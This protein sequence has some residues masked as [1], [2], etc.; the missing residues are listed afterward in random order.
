MSE[1]KTMGLWRMNGI[2][3]GKYLVM[4]RDGTV[5]D[6]PHFVIGARDPASF[7]ALMA[8][9]AEAERLNAVAA[10]SGSEGLPTYNQAFI[11]DVRKMAFEFDD[12]RRKNGV[13]DP[14][15]PPHRKDDPDVVSKMK[16][17]A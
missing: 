5:P 2:K 4:R 12:Y 16:G 10:R 15:A 13:G 8:Y 6:W 1:T 17:S 7:A 11:D 3:G 14:D 9:A